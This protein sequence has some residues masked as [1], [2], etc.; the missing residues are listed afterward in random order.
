MQKEQYTKLLKTFTLLYI[1]D[2]DNIRNNLVLTLNLIFK[3]VIA[4]ANSEDAL[5]IYKE[6]KIDIILSDINLPRMSG[7][8]FSKIIRKE[9]ISIPII[10]LSAY[11]DTNFLLEAAKL[12]LISY[13]TKPINFDELLEAFKLGVDDIF[14]DNQSLIEFKNNISYNLSNSILYENDKEKDLTQSER[15]LLQLFIQRKN[16]TISIEEIKNYIWEDSYKATDSAF[17]SL[18]NKLRYKI[19][20]ESIKNVSGVGYRLVIL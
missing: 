10:L 6:K 17:K 18:L 20:Q 11:T 14:R 8:D 1:E 13:L 2:E 12:K 3:D 9:N 16:T 7:L 15:K 19:G 4:V 5:K